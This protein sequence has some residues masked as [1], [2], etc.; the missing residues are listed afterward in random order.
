MCFI[1]FFLFS[2]IREDT[3]KVLRILTDDNGPMRTFDEI[4]AYLE[5]HVYKT[6]RV[7]LVVEELL[8]LN[9]EEEGPR[10][11]SP[12]PLPDL[13]DQGGNHGKGKGMGKN[14][15]KSMLERKGTTATD[16]VEENNNYM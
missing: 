10:I 4:Y 5:A 1:S 12:N 16:V 13:E 7:Q 9:D 2:K 14:S 8:G 3:T 11:A 6:N 15:R